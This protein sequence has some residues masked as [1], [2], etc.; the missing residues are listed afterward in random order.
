MYSTIINPET[1]I[2]VNINGELGKKILGNY[3]KILSGGA[4]KASVV[5]GE[6]AF[7]IWQYNIL[8]REYTKYNSLFHSPGSVG[9]GDKP[10]ESTDITK[11]RYTMATNKILEE[12][13]DA[14]CLQECSKAFFSPEFNESSAALMEKYNVIPNNEGEPGV[15]ILI[16]KVFSFKE[17]VNN[18]ARVGGT[19]T[20]RTGGKS[21]KGLGV[22]VNIS[23]GKQIWVCCVH[24]QWEKDGGGK[25][26]ANNLL[27]DL[28]N[29]IKG[30]DAFATS[31]PLVLTGDFNMSPDELPLLMVPFLGKDNFHSFQKVDFDEGV[32]IDDIVAGTETL[33]ASKSPPT[34]LKGDFSKEIEI[35]YILYKNLNPPISKNI[36]MK[37]T[38]SV[39][40]DDGIIKSGGPYKVEVDGSIGI[41]TP[42]DHGFMEAVFEL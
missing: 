34:G 22:L 15:C 2:N 38:K 30:V 41:Q 17:S 12:S 39:K 8:A 42:S 33:R 37:P 7:K 29:E 28:F 40:G 31:K 32:N 19:N 16:K 20:S 25:T 10:L 5:G 27:S 4:L 26:Q 24:L 21:K 35:D 1:G 23:P 6:T 14:V 36:Y 3:L 11:Q 13:P 18:I 9:K